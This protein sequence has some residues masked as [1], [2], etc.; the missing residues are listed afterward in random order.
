M[1]DEATASLDKLRSDI[2]RI[3]RELHTLLRERAAV[4]KRIGLAKRSSGGVAA[5]IVRP[6]REANVIRAL[7]E[8]HDGAMPVASV[9]R[10]WRELIADACQMQ[11]PFR[12]ALHAPERSISHWDVVRNHFG[13][14]API[15]LC[16]SAQRVL[17]ELEKPGT[18]GVLPWPDHDAPTPWWP[19]MATSDVSANIV[20]ALPFF[21]SAVGHFE[22]RRLMV[23]AT[24]PAEESGDDTSYI[25]V[26]TDPE[27]SRTRLSGLLDRHG[28]SG[29]VIAT[30]G[31]END[32]QQLLEMDGFISRDDERIAA[33]EQQSEGLIHRAIP[34]GAAARPVGM[35]DE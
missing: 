22:N 9:A 31:R 10:I 28:L 1:A 25:V 34:I 35:L 27:L 24:Y 33:L 19:H 26:Q 30:S 32:F 12:I 3:D 13:T 18:I 23:V 16:G 6:G 29:H 15:T 21:E 4:V 20:T 5:P 14:I 11:S 7:V 2:D 17:Q 8:R